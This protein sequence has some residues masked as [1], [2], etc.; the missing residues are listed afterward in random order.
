MTSVEIS[1]KTLESI[2][3]QFIYYSSKNFENL[4]V[5]FIVHQSIIYDKKIP[6]S[7][8]NYLKY[9]YVQQRN[10]FFSLNFV[11]INSQ[12][13]AQILPFSYC[14]S[15]NI[16]GICILMNRFSFFFFLVDSLWICNV[17]RKIFYT[18]I[19]GKKKRAKLLKR[20]A[21]TVCVFQC[22]LA[23]QSPEAI[24][25]KRESNEVI[26]STDEDINFSKIR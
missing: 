8:Y 18:Y 3:F 22:R 20:K 12:M 1:D 11:C 7:S 16:L 23:R 25:F 26:Y 21:Y 2:L 9:L 10:F 6:K 5:F 15:Q 13:F 24:V 17:E 19:C 14:R 4:F